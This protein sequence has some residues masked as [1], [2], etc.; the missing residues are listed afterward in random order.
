MSA[1]ESSVREMT[2]EVYI[3]VFVIHLRC[4]TLSD[5]NCIYLMSQISFLATLRE[6]HYDMFLVPDMMGMCHSQTVSLEA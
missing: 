4:H 2:R 1:S 6:A 3:G 5:P